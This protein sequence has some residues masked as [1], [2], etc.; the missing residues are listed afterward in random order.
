[1]KFIS[2]LLITSFLLSNASIAENMDNTLCGF[3]GL[4][5]R[6]LFG[7]FVAKTKA[8]VITGTT[9]INTLKVG[10][11]GTAGSLSLFSGTASKGSWLFTPVDNTGNTVMTIT[12]AAQAGAYTYTIPSAGASA[13]FVMTQGTQTVVGSTTFTAAVTPTGGIG[14]AGGFAL[15]PRGIFTGHKGA[16]ISTDGVDQTPVITETYIQEINVPGNC[17]ITGVALMWGA[18]ST[19]N[20]QVSLANA[21]TGAPIAAAQSV[22]TAGSGTTAYQLIPFATPYAA[23]GP[24]TYLIL[25]QF[26][27]ASARPRVHTLGIHG[28]SKKTGETYGTFTTVTPPTTFTT[29]LGQFISLY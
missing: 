16:D 3:P 22:S 5:S 19:G 9:Q 29:L 17:T 4:Q 13:S 11:S 27:N 23:V 14:A 21:V 25:V 7:S 10:T 12:N 26:N 28:V 2:K 20:V 8:N 1:M 24:A 18:A 15:T 6:C